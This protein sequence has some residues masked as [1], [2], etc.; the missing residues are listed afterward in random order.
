MKKYT[1]I[2]IGKCN[3]MYE[4]RHKNDSRCKTLDLHDDCS[5]VWMTIMVS[6][7]EHMTLHLPV[8]I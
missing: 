4:I 5:N 2:K 6:H 1:F 8:S 7:E 3:I